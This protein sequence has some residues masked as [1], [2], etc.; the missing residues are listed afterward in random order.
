MNSIFLA[1]EI[2]DR[3]PL[4]EPSFDWLPVWSSALIVAVIIAAC[5]VLPT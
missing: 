5:L 4:P 1:F 2:F 3:E